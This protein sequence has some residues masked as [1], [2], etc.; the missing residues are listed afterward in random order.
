MAV[1]DFS[2][3]NIQDTYQKVVQTD[4]TDLAD[5]T[6]SLLPIKFDGPD[7]IVSGAVRANSYIVSESITSVSSGSTAFGN[8]TDDTHTFIGNVTASGNI[9]S[10]G[11]VYAMNTVAI[12]GASNGQTLTQKAGVNDFVMIE[13]GHIT[14]Y[15]NIS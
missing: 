5:G 2:N 9:S 12:T 4:G 11:N 14:A 10:S 3:Q 8:S 6:G 15:G 13:N 7:L 1:N